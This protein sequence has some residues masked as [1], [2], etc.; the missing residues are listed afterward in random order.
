MRVKMD[1]SKVTLLLLVISSILISA[2]LA[3][4]ELFDVWPISNVGRVLTVNVVGKGKILKSPDQPGYASG[5]N[6]TL[7]PVADTE[8]VFYGWSGD[9]VSGKTSPLSITLYEDITVTANFA[10]VVNEQYGIYLNQSL[11][12][13]STDPAVNPYKTPYFVHG[14]GLGDYPV[15]RVVGTET[16]KPMRTGITLSNVVIDDDWY[17]SMYDRGQFF[18]I[19]GYPATF[20]STV[21]GGSGNSIINCTLRNS[22]RYGLTTFGASNFYIGYNFVES[23]QHCLTGSGTTSRNGLIEYNYVQHIHSDGFKSRAMQNV[24]VRYN[25]FDLTPF[26]SGRNPIGAD[27]NS[28]V[29]NNNMNVDIHHNIFVKD[30]G[31]SSSLRGYIFAVEGSSQGVP[32][33]NGDLGSPGIPNL[34]FRDN[35][36]YKIGGGTTYASYIRGNY[37]EVTGNTFINMDSQIVQTSDCVG[38]IVSPNTFTTG[39]DVPQP[40]LPMD[41]YGAQIRARAPSPPP[42]EGAQIVIDSSMIDEELTDFPLM[43]KISNPSILNHDSKSISITDSGGSQCYVEIESW[44]SSEAFL[45]V[46]VPTISPSADT[47]LIL[48]LLD[49][50]NT[51]YVGNTLDPVTHNVWSN[52]Y[53]GVFHFAGHLYDSSAEGND[54]SVVSTDG[55][56]ISFVPAKVGLGAEFVVRS[57]A[58][59]KIRI[60]DHPNYSPINNDPWTTAYNGITT[61]RICVQMQFVNMEDWQAAPYMG[62]RVPLRKGDPGIEYK[63]NVFGSYEEYAGRRFYVFTPAGGFGSGADLGARTG[64]APTQVGTW[65]LLHGQTFRDWDDGGGIV[66]IYENAT[67]GFGVSGAGGRYRGG[68]IDE[69]IGFNNYAYG[70]GVPPDWSDDIE[71]ADTDGPLWIGNTPGFVGPPHSVIDEVRISK[72]NRNMAWMKAELHN[73]NGELV[74]VS[75]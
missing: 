69:D 18:G 66:G 37:I 14:P 24:E 70:E 56:D 64:H 58:S 4:K 15:F 57:T 42:T 12:G 74:T 32:D 11:D 23:A 30:V 59:A 5:T 2:P 50:Q 20:A 71:I 61:G 17:G 10:F 1:K 60:P 33:V 47:K 31:I 26:H 67:A 35:T 39:T 41:R 13:I 63:F 40:Q 19:R 38:N 25:Y 8:Y 72:V 46:K 73:M 6:V 62:W 49:S 29:P 55:T 52:G 68:D 16:D 43:V 9:G 53:V 3:I 54:A 7:T 27:Y 75:G 28:D 36:A 22:I 51:A 45:W 21:V 44:D 34:K 48:N 65:Y